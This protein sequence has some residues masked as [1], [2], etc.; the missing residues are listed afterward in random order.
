MSRLPLLLGLVYIHT[1]PCIHTCTREWQKWC[2]YIVCMNELYYAQEYW[3]TFCIDPIFIE[4]EKWMRERENIDWF[5]N[6]CVSVMDFVLVWRRQDSSS[7][8]AFSTS[9][10]LV[11]LVLYCLFSPS[12]WFFIT[13]HSEF[14]QKPQSFCLVNQD[15]G[16][17][18]LF[19]SV[20]IFVGFAIL[21]S[22]VLIWV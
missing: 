22:D 13:F 8:M 17:V 3:W 2:L 1:Y 9:S 18:S 15:S 21:L 7:V 14:L 20:L 10:Y 16:I 12:S 4:R 11:V 19:Y 5:G 6:L